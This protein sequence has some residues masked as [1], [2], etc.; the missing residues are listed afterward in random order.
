MFEEFIYVTTA[1]LAL[2]VGTVAA[3]MSVLTWD[4]FRT[5]T[6]G[7]AIIGVAVAFSV[8]TLHH[9]F[10]ISIEPRPAET[11]MYQALLNTAILMFIV[12]M[13]RHDRRLRTDEGKSV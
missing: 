8:F 4:I 2:V 11:R 10:I 5:S 13:I 6:F 1:L 7:T 3:T 9:V 12:M